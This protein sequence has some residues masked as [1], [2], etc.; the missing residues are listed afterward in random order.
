MKSYDELTND[1][2]ERRD[3]YVADQKKKRKRVMG[4]A[5]SLC[6]FCLVALLGFGMWQ[7]GMFNTTPPDET[8]MMLY[9][10]A[11]RIPLMIRMANLS[12]TLLRTTRLLLT[13]SMGFRL[14]R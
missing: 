3:R 5:T 2:L 14:T 8:S 4:V 9:T 6:C 13:P 10:P 7:G 1:L 11:S 12:T